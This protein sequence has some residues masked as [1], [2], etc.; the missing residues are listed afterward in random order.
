[1]KN[2]KKIGISLATVSILGLGFTGCTE[3]EETQSSL[4]PDTPTI[5]VD[6]L[7]ISS[8]GAK[9]TWDVSIDNTHPS[10]KVRIAP[11]N[12]TTYYWS[13][14][15]DYSDHI[16]LGCNSEIGANG[17]IQCND[18]TSITCN[19]VM[20]G[21]DYSE[22]QCD[23]SINN[24][25][26]VPQFQ[27]KMRVAT[28]TNGTPSEDTLLTIGTKYYYENGRYEAIDWVNE[29]D[30]SNMYNVYTNGIGKF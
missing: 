14:S 19:R 11:W 5:V 1:M 26:M 28:R 12:D 21:S 23:F 10:T 3:E 30:T 9:L 15:T 16:E 29:T 25:I 6:K 8:S 2:L 24:S 22:Y 7:T 13:Y 20:M 4:Y 18:I 27:K 17:N